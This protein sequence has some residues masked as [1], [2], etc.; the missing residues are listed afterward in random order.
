[1]TVRRVAFVVSALVLSG[2]IGGCAGWFGWSE[3]GDEPDYDAVTVQTLHGA[4]VVPSPRSVP[5][6]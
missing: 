5:G 4:V 6:R 2:L 1:M 3:R